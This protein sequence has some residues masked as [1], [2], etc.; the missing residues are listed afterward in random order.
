MALGP[1]LCP[2]S[3]RRRGEAV[4]SSAAARPSPDAAPATSPGGGG[5][6]VVLIAGRSGVGKSSVGFEVSEVLQAAGVAHVL[7]DGDNLNAGYPKPPGDPHGSALG[8][9][10]LTALWA[11]YAATGQR[12][13]IYV[14]TVS[15]LEAPMIVRAVGGA[16]RVVAVLLTASDQVAAARLAQREV[17]SALENHVQRSK[18]MAVH[19]EERAG[20]LVVCVPTDGRTVGQ[21]AAD[22]IALTGWARRAAPG[23]SAP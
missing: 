7:V 22:V 12:R 11:N 20:E 15:V 19:L 6:E 2:T 17:A 16:A 14:N 10:N 18:A 23:S 8:E 9:A 5:V 13:M 21:V 3:A 1:P 4:V